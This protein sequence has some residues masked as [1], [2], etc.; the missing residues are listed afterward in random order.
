M[1]YTGRY[2]SPLGELLLAADDAGL[3]GVWFQGQKY[4][5]H[6]LD[7]AA[8]AG[9]LPVLDETRRWLDRYFSGRDPGPVPPLHPMGTDFQKRVWSL[10]LSIPR[11]QTATYG[12][13]AKE[14]AGRPVLSRAVGGAV[15]HN[16]I[17][18]LIPCHR[19]V[20]AGGRLTG[21][22]GG[23]ERKRALLALE[24]ADGVRL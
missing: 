7:P 23:L 24:G 13:L 4:F 16:P 9:D 6:G 17:S 20:G 1:Q 5:G 18:I 3:T 8:Q 14:L 12:A 22:A 15:G 2:L 11:G 21:Y 10:L 19:V